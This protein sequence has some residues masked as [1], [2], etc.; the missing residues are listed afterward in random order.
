MFLCVVFTPILLRIPKP[1]LFMCLFEINAYLS[2]C[3]HKHCI[4]DKMNG[5]PVGVCVC[6]CVRLSVGLKEGE[7][8]PLHVCVIEE[9]H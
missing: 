6:V 1:F 4:V 8:L 3:T 2:V 9:P 5:R 7:G